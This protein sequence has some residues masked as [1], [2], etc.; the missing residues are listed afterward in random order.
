ME[1]VAYIGF[2]DYVKKI[3]EIDCNDI[4]NIMW[5]IESFVKN[6]KGLQYRGKLYRF[7]NERMTDLLYDIVCGYKTNYPEKIIVIPMDTRYFLVLSD[8]IK[9]LN[10]IK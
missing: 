8:T 4:S 3:Y 10:N 2:E 1:K 7:D 9:Y 5:K 6:Y